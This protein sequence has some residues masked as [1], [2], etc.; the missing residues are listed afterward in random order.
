MK[1]Q[2]YDEAI[3]QSFYLSIA[4]MEKAKAKCKRLGI[5]FSALVNDLLEK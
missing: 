2:K 5:R 4:T 1:Y 3:Y